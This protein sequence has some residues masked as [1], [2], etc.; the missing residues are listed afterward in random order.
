MITKRIQREV[1]EATISLPGKQGQGVLVGG[2]LILTAAHCI[3]FECSGGMV[4]GDHYAEDVV[5]ASM[6]LKAAPLAI[7]PLHDIAALG[8]PDDQTFPDD[9][10][11]FEKFCESTKPVQVCMDDLQLFKTFRVYVLTHKGTWTEGVAELCSMDNPMLAIESDEQI[12]GGTS[13][14]PIVN[15]SDELVG[16]VSSFSDAKIDQ[17]GGQGFAP[18]PHL[19]LPVWIWDRI[20]R[21]P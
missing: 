12:E 6:N 16:I 14:G 1:A 17:V 18:R 10:L 9:A 15:D 21:Q 13:G 3:S 20:S 4:L 5:T 11:T 8:S 19:A 2:N 7:E